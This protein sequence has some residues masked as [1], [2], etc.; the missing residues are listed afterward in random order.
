MASG[1]GPRQAVTVPVSAAVVHWQQ[2]GRGVTRGE[3]RYAELH[4]LRQNLGS[5]SRQRDVPSS[6][7]QFT[8]G[9]R[10]AS[11]SVTSKMANGLGSPAART[12]LQAIKGHLTHP[13]TTTATS[14][15]TSTTSPVTTRAFS[16]SASSSSSSSSSSESACVIDFSTL[17]RLMPGE[18]TQDTNERSLWYVVATAALMGYHQEAGVGELWKYISTHSGCSE[19]QLVTIARRIRETCLKA[20]VLVGFPRGINSLLSLQSALSSA[21][22]SVHAVLRADTSLREPLAPS[23]KWE[24]G[25]KFFSQIYANHTDRILA[26]MGASSGGDLSYFALAS[27]YGELMG[28]MSIV[29]PMETVMLEFVCC[30]A[31]DVAP[32]AKGHFFGCRNLG[33]TGKQVQGAIEVVREVARQLG[34]PAAGSGTKFEFLEKASTW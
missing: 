26:S 24:R 30:L 31:D 2:A 17:P 1:L 18:S 27:V 11:V 12:R 14:P 3:R 34:R 9:S 32:Q 22:P 15:T 6:I 16:S 5:Y 8:H 33:A 7:H 20:S 29:N 25:K 23:V 10:S 21:T 4:R 13:T 28:E 19:A